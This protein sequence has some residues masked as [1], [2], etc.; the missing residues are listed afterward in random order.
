M[1]VFIKENLIT[2]VKAKVK[3]FFAININT[4]II[5]KKKLKKIKFILNTIIISKKII[6]P[7]YFLKTI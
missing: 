4:I 6:I 2:Q 3:F 5:R 7:I 1:T